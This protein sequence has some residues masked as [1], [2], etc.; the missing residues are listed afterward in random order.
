MLTQHDIDVMKSDVMDILKSWGMTATI[1]IPKPED[2]QTNFN[3]IMREYTGDIDYDIIKDVP[4]ERLE[5]VNEYHEDKSHI[6][7]GDKVESGYQYKFPEEFDGKP[8]II[9]PNMILIFNDDID[10]KYQINTIRRRIGE[11]IVDVDL[12]TGG[13]D[14][15]VMSNGI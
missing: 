9:K 5:V 12:I 4:V 11:T 2:E 10:K 7:A 15:G 3:K 14:S 1:M 6:K 13:T 8:L